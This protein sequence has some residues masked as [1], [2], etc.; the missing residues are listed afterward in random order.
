MNITVTAS[1]GGTTWSRTASIEVDTA[2]SH[3]GQTPGSSYIYG[4]EAQAPE[5]GVHSYSGIAV[6]IFANKGK[7]QKMYVILSGT[8]GI[9]PLVQTHMPLIVYSGAGTG[10]TGAINT[11]GTSTDTCTVDITKVSL[12]TNGTSA[13]VVGLKAIS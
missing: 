10:F 7:S 12:M 2:A 5:L 13:S 9:S 4:T 6:G 3:Q 11:S 8:V 1:S